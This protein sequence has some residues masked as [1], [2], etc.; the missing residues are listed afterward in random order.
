MAQENLNVS[1]PNDGLGDQLRAAF[2]KQQANN[3][4]LYANKVDKD[5]AK[6]LSTNDFTALLKDKL[7]NIE[8][9][10]ERNVQSDALQTDP[11]A[12]DFI[13]NFPDFPDLENYL[14]KGAYEGADAQSI[15]AYVNNGL[16]NKVVLDQIVIDNQVAEFNRTYTNIGTAIYTDPT[17]LF[18][19]GYKVYVRFGTATIGG[20][21]YTQGQ[22]IIRT[23]NTTWRSDVYL[24]STEVQV[25]DNQIPISANTTLSSIHN[26]QTLMISA[27]VT[28]TI[29]ASL[30]S[31][32]T[33]NF[34]TL[35]GATVTW[36]IIAPH[37]F[38]FGSPI[39]VI[40]KS[41]GNLTK[42]GSTNNIII[43]GF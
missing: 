1:T 35:V 34:I 6:V 43:G 12:D 24:P 18:G 32:F 21:A 41:Y 37:V 28:L 10:A 7:D 3:T 40:E 42:Q 20:V 30:P 5:G 2:V 19:N 23:F 4:D 15:I 9:Y 13:K 8:A 39:V 31:E 11:L 33:F 25:K 27:A 14:L 17:G 29:P 26:G 38:A 22:Y 16:A 36:A